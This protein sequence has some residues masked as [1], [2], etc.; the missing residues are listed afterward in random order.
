MVTKAILLVEYP[1]GPL[2]KEKASLESY[3]KY[4]LIPLSIFGGALFVYGLWIATA[5]QA[6]DADLLTMRNFKIVSAVAGGVGG[7]FGL[8]A[9]GSALYQNHQLKHFN[10]ELSAEEETAIRTANN[11][12]QAEG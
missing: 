9:T 5:V 4:G 3:E 7:L 2:A 11:L 12:H 10:D 8:I 6:R 1:A